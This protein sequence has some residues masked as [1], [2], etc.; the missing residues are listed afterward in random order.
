MFETSVIESK[1]TRIK[2]ASVALVPVSVTIHTLV[3]AGAV[4][5][6]LVNVSFPL[7]TPAQTES[8][9]PAMA[10]PLP[11]PAPAPVVV[12]PANAP[13]T[14]PTAIVRDMAP[15]MIPDEVHPA[16]PVT[17]SSAPDPNAVEGGVPGGSGDSLFGDPNSV[18]TA[19]PPDDLGPMVVGGEVKPPV[20]I[21]RV[22]PVYPNALRILKREGSVAV[23]CVIDKE[24][25]VRDVQV[26][27]STLEAF[28]DSATSAVR[29]W[30]FRPGTYRGRAV[31]TVF[32]LRVDFH[33]NR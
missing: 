1:R 11:P 25:T 17:G 28:A 31:D 4:V 13:A 20:V 19:A 9:R 15:N 24:G 18:G 32:I 5:G 2:A 29:Q 3:I 10:A 12:R 26:L 14:A 8:L 22:D 16:T 27:N 30:R 6:A 7:N 21:S 33:L 23:Q